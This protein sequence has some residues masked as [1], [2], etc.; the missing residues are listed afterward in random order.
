[1]LHVLD[2]TCPNLVRTLPDLPYDKTKVEDVDSKVEDHC[3]ATG[4]LVQTETGSVPI[5][6]VSVGDRVWTRSGLREVTAAGVTSPSALVG[7]VVL[8]NGQVLRGTAGHPVFVLERGWVS[9][10]ALRYGDRLYAWQT[11][12]ESSSTALSFGAIPT[13]VDALSVS[14]SC[15]TGAIA[16]TASAVSTRRSGKRPTVQFPTVTTST[17]AT[18]TRL[19]TTSATWNVCRSAATIIATTLRAFCHRGWTLESSMPPLPHGTGPLRAASGTASTG[20]TPGLGDSPSSEIV[21]NAGDATGLCPVTVLSGSVRTS[22]S[23][24]F[25]VLAASMTSSA[26]VPSA[27]SRSGATVTPRQSAAPAVVGTWTASQREPVYNLTVPDCPEFFANGVLVHNCADALRYALQMMGGVGSPFVRQPERPKPTTKP[28]TLTP[29][30]GT[31]VSP[32][33]GNGHDGNGSHA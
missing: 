13:P 24:R 33:A 19:T 11:S 9:L 8:S 32:F 1:M 29:G 16:R 23:R 4:T 30:V 20:A 15:P 10:D 27:A 5:E 28:L 31:A 14:T 17:T 26:S 2:G 3:L 25:D 18:S 12:S 7:T 21:I 6:T 22:A